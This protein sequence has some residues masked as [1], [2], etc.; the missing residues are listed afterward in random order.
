ML[1]VSSVDYNSSEK[2]YGIMDTD[3]NVIEFYTKDELK[4]ILP[5]IGYTRIKGVVYTGSD[6]KIHITT[7]V[8]EYINNLPRGSEF[9]LKFDDG[10]KYTY[11]KISE[12]SG[13]IGWWVSKNN[14]V[15]CKLLKQFLLANMN[16]ITLLRD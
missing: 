12:L 5:I 6:L 3:D 4:K 14:Q 1:Y 8:I 13:A 11:K 7:P 10:S 2:K 16:K 9:T 15:Q